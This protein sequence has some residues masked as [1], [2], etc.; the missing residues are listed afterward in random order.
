MPVF[1][2]VLALLL[3]IALLGWLGVY[4]KKKYAFVPGYGQIHFTL[5]EDGWRIALCRY[6]PERKTRLFPVILCHGLGANRFN[7]DLGPRRSLARHLQARGFEVWTLD[8]RGRGLS[9]LSPENPGPACRPSGFD[10]YVHRDARAAIACVKRESGAPQVHW[11][12]HSMGGL[13]LYALL[14]GEAARDIASG[15]AVA[16]PGSFEH[17]RRIP[18]VSPLFRLFRL[19]PRVRQSFLAAAL[20]PVLPLLPR[21]V[22]R[23]VLNPANVEP[24]YVKRALCHLVS[25]LTRGE[26]QQ[27]SDWID[28]REFRSCDKA[29]SY[30]RHL[31]AIERP[32]LL[33]AGTRDYLASAESVSFTRERLSGERSRM[34]ILGRKFG[35]IEDY[36]HGDLL[37]GRHCEQEVYPRIVEW[38]EAAEAPGTALPVGE[39]S[40]G[41]VACP[42]ASP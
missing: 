14:Q 6:L 17:L 26:A 22:L 21:S 11:V 7:F 9:G 16:S 13:I 1:N 15:T 36:G 34:L 30:Q 3:V 18:G 31:G 23:L 41:A 27:F 42:G 39:G 8:L 29:Y 32:L 24:L 37:I 38:L 12:G 10:D 25:D 19:L 40:A 35:Q 2:G 5:T 20:A 28:N 33:M 4:W